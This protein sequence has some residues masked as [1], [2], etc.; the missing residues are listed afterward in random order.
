MYYKALGA[1]TLSTGAE[2]LTDLDNRLVQQ[3][4]LKSGTV[5]TK[6]HLG[7]TSTIDLRT[8]AWTSGGHFEIHVN[9]IPYYFPVYS[10]P[11]GAQL[12]Y[13]FVIDYNFF[14]FH[15]R[16]PQSSQ[17]G[18]KDAT[19]GSP[20]AF[21]GYTTVTPFDTVN[22]TDLDGLQ[23]SFGS[24]ISTAAPYTPNSATVTQ[25]KN[26]SGTANQAAELLCWRPAIQDITTLGDAPPTY[27]AGTGYF[28]SKYA[29]VDGT[30]GL[31]GEL[32]NIAFASENYIL[33]DDP[34]Q[35]F[36]DSGIAY[37]GGD[38]WICHVVAGAGRAGNI[39]GYHPFGK[40]TSNNVQNS[41]NSGYCSGPRL[42]IRRS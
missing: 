6:S 23:V 9:G 38:T 4:Y 17:T 21:C 1:V 34:G 41:N 5:Y 12:T 35:P 18:T 20:W 10:A 15:I 28:G 19:Y 16:G 3:G 30:N 42:F 14:W 37:H 13:Q 33:G 39:P 27:I 8:T 26:I 32:D 31:R 24:H 22:D 11:I 40:T 25:K 2:I 29:L 36:T 7:R